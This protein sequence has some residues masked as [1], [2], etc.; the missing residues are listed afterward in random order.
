VTKKEAQEK[1]QMKLLGATQSIRL[2]GV[3]VLMSP[4]DCFDRGLLHTTD[5][6]FLTI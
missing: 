2:G 3:V 5:V 4:C 1:I 6:L